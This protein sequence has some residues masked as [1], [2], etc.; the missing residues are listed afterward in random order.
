MQLRSLI[1]LKDMHLPEELLKALQFCY[2]AT[3]SAYSWRDSSATNDVKERF[4]FLLLQVLSPLA[5]LCM[6][7]SFEP[8]CEWLPI[9]NR[10]TDILFTKTL[11]GTFQ[12]KRGSWAKVAISPAIVGI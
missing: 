1:S 7:M 3:P 10:R 8:Y 11:T 9:V 12:E 2:T 6:L 4:V 5:L